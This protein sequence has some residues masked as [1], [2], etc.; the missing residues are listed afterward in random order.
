MSCPPVLLCHPPLPP[1]FWGKVLPAPR[2]RGVGFLGA[3]LGAP[4]PI[5]PL[6]QRSAGVEAFPS[7]GGWG[8]R[9]VEA[10][11]PPE[12]GRPAGSPA[13][14]FRRREVGAS[15]C[16]GRRKVRPPL[17]SHPPP[18]S[19]PG[20]SLASRRGGWGA[21]VVEAFLSAGYGQP[22]GSPAA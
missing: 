6:P 17:S 1:H 14:V 11:L 15:A 20:S 2:G 8:A 21:R 5:L 12:G 9:A 7:A 18:V 3:A 16:S 10:F 4:A 13:A 22:A 19:R